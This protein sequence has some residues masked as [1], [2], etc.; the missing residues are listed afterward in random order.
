MMRPGRRA[1]LVLLFVSVS[2]LSFAVA[3]AAGQLTPPS[4]HAIGPKASPQSPQPQLV[5]LGRGTEDASRVLATLEGGF[6]P[7]APVIPA[8]LPPGYELAQAEAR[9]QAG[10][11]ALLDVNYVAAGNAQIHLFQANFPNS[12]QVIAAIEARDELMIKGTSWRY[13]VLSFPQPSGSPLVVHF[14]ERPFDGHTYVS[15][16]L[17]SRGDHAAEK[18]QLVGII[19]SLH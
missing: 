3:S 10:Q 17:D 9:V 16:G 19:A 12:K 2:L 13:L 4:R 14:A 6:L 15:V 5:L 8:S 11:S 18:A 7:F 1:R